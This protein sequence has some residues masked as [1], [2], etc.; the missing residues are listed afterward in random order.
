MG[1]DNDRLALLA[2]AAQDS[3]KLFDLLRRQDRR[4]LIENQ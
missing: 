2:H 1:D 3:E 4:R